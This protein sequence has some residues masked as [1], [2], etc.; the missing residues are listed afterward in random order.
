M[1]VGVVGMAAVAVVAIAATTVDVMVAATTRVA[2]L[3][4]GKIML[5]RGPSRVLHGVHLVPTPHALAFLV[6]DR[7]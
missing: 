5:P 6:L 2:M 3:L 7:L 4:N 1:V